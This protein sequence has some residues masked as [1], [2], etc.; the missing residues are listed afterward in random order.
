MKKFLLTAFLLLVAAPIVT[1]VVIA[2]MSANNQFI[3]G[4]TMIIACIVAS[5]CSKKHFISFC[6]LSLARAVIYDDMVLQYC[7]PH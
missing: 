5:V 3:F 7:A 4:I 1:L 2:P 6:I